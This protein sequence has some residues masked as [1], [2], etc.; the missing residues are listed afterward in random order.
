[1]FIG[2]VRGDSLTHLE[3]RSSPNEVKIQYNTL[4]LC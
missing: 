2:C 4:L 3:N 1:M